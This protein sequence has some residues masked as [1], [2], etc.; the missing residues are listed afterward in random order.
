MLHNFGFAYKLIGRYGAQRYAKTLTQGRKERKGI[1]SMMKQLGI[2]VIF[3]AFLAHGLVVEAQDMTLTLVA[4]QD[5]GTDCPVASTFQPGTD[6][7]WVLM[8]NCGGYRYSLVAYDR[9][10]GE[11]LPQ[12]PIPLA[13]IDGDIYDVFS[14]SEPFAFTPDGVLQIMAAEGD[15]FVR[16]QIDVESGAVTMD[17]AE[18]INTLLGQFSEYPAFATTFSEEH[19]YAAV[20]DDVKFYILDFTTGDVLFEIE[21]LGI[22]PFFSGDGQRLYV[23]ILDEPENYEN[24]DGKIVVY[25]LPD[26]AVLNSIEFPFSVLYPSDDGRY[27]VAE[28]ASPEVGKE[29]LAVVDM[30]GG[31][32]SAMLPISV[33]SRKAMTCHNTGQDISDVDFTASGK[34]FIRGLSW[35]PDNSGF[36]TVN[37]YD[38]MQTNTGCVFEYSRMRQ[39]SVGS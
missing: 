6:V 19:R 13:E 10:S 9:N 32:V 15:F 34:L 37:A 20:T 4:E 24:F 12:A 2:L 7:M 22:I 17:D 29:Q 30:E 1:E 5:I 33:P 25:S 31:S 39:Y 14:F 23:S 38:G 16:F 36:I 27:I 11:A 28:V 35:L 26:G 21:T 8:D 18:E 3:C